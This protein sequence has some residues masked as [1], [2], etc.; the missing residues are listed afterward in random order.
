MKKIKYDKRYITKVLNSIPDHKLRRMKS[1]IRIG[2][3]KEQIMKEFK[4]IE[5]FAD[6]V[7]DK[8]I[9]PEIHPVEAR[10]GS[11]TEP[12]YK[13]ESDMIIPE[14]KLED[15]TGDE[16]KI[17]NKDYGE[18]ETSLHGSSSGGWTTS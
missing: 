3:T 7:Y 11:K 16:L 8:Y 18:D 17:A 4:I 5:S 2:Y 12:Y 6:I 10:L 1:C 15:L 14:Y 13:K 9:I